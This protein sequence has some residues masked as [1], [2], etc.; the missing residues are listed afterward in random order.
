MQLNTRACIQVEVTPDREVGTI[1]FGAVGAM[2]TAAAAAMC[3]RDSQR[4]GS[5]QP[6]ARSPLWAALTSQPLDEDDADD[7]ETAGEDSQQLDER[8]IVDIGERMKL[9]LDIPLRF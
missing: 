4:R 6:G 3:N 2:G 9:F 1:L 5:V 7:D 8:S